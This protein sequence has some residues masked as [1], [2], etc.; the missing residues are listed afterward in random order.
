MLNVACFSSFVEQLLSE[1]AEGVC[2]WREEQSFGFCCLNFMWIWECL[3]S[4]RTGAVLFLSHEVSV[5]WAAVIS[6]VTNRTA[7]L[8]NKKCGYRG[9]IRN[10]VEERG[11]FLSG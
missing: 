2:V 9:L 8:A 6:T 11:T 10:D 3:C 7:E 1:L 4:C 5:S